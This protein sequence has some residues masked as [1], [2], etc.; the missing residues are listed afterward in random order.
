VG[1][2][3]VKAPGSMAVGLTVGTEDT[4]WLI[5]GGSTGVVEVPVGAASTLFDGEV[6][7][8]SHV[9]A[10]R[11]MNESELRENILSKCFEYRQ[12]VK[13]AEDGGDKR[14]RLPELE[15]LILLSKTLCLISLLTV[16]N[17]FE[18]KRMPF[19]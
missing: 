9:S 15:L 7:S 11:I 4:V 6:R 18:T 12:I 19:V 1:G 14:K 2:G 8:R 17:P 13:E 10:P 3:G 16:C 5:G